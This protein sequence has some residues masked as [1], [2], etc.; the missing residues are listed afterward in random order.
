MKLLV[1]KANKFNSWIFQF[2]VDISLYGFTTFL[3]AIVNG[4]GYT[5]VTAN[6]MTVPIYVWGLITFLFTAY[7]SDKTGNRGYWIGGPLVCLIIGYALLISVDN[8]GVRY[9]ACFGA[10][11]RAKNFSMHRALLI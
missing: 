1:H 3:P 8:L 2:A 5:S 6:L 11:L 7:M 9:F 4:L 10:F